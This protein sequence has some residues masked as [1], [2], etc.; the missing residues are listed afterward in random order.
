METYRLKNIAILILLLLNASL[1]LLL[2]HQYLQAQRGAR[3]A[4]G[5][6]HQLY[7]AGQLE[8]DEDIDLTQQSLSPLTLVRHSESERSIAAFLLG[9]DAVS[10]SQGGGIYSYEAEA[11]AI[12]FRAGGS[13][14]GSRL[15]LQVDDITDFSRQFCRQFG[16]EDAAFQ[17]KNRS[18]TVTAVQQMAGVPIAGCNVTLHF[19]S[20]VLTA[21]SGAH[22]SLE[23]ASAEAGGR[24]SCITALVRFL[25]HR[26]ASGIVCSKVTGVSCVYEL[27]GGGALR[28]LP[29]W[30][31][32]TDTYTYFVDCTTGEVTRH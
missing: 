18:G 12:Q 4:A 21:V 23:D 1:L 22:V 6:L 15:T 26:S 28:L 32:E 17:I 30:Q 5:Q 16:Y 2:G 31:V 20:G 14:D 29:K 7:T 25:D 24:M 11:G 27:Q 10:A 9:G 8:L 13:F 19:D 3:D